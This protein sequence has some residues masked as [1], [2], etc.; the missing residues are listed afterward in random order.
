MALVRCSFRG[1][2]PVKPCS[3]KA[4]HES[5][6]FPSNCVE[7]Q[8]TCKETGEPVICLP[9]NREKESGKKTFIVS[10]REVH[11]QPY[12]ALAETPE[13]AIELVANCE[14]NI[15]DADFE[16]SHTLDSDTWTVE[17]VKS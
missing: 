1:K 4:V 16:F 5:D 12:L 17:E 9:A 15:L 3:H 6:N 11:V 14:G 7:I 8:A 13:E 2:C 10:V